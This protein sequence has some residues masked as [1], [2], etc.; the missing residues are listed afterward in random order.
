MQ[1]K[2]ITSFAGTLQCGNNANFKMMVTTIQAPL[3]L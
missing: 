1:L 3:K 2:P